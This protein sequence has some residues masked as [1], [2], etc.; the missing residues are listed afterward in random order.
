MRKVVESSGSGDD[1][2]GALV[3]VLEVGLVL[4]DRDTTKIASE[5]QLRFLEVATYVRQD[6][7]SLLK[8]L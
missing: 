2:V 6:L 5:S 4:F 1:D 8:S 7:P 3:R